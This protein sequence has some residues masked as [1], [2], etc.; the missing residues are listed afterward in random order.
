MLLQQSVRLL[1]TGCQPPTLAVSLL[2]WKL[3]TTLYDLSEPESK[4][5]QSKDGDSKDAENNSVTCEGS[6]AQLKCES[7]Q[8]I[9]VV[10]AN[11]GRLDG[12]KCSRGRPRAQLRNAACKNPANKVSEKCDGKQ[13][14]FIKASNSVFGDPCRGTYKYLEVDFINSVTCEGATAKLRCAVGQVISILE[15]NYGRLES[16]KC[17]K[18]RP[19]SQLRNV[20]CSNPAS[21]FIITVR[22][23]FRCDGKRSCNIRASNSM[24]G[25]PC[26]GTY[27][28]LE[29][30]YVCQGESSRTH[31]PE[32]FTFSIC[33]QHCAKRSTDRLTIQGPDDSVTVQS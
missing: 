20:K 10:K 16:G 23:R 2:G 7:G 17:A 3:T 24:F 31:Y 30:D 21:K 25:D 11:Y 1:G 13:K 19:K 26:R 4:D 33:C 9:S 28:Y 8:V 5:R 14:C 12:K 18:G 27:K 32:R 22:F 6:M 29:V 15:A